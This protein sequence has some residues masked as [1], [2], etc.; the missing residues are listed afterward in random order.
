MFPNILQ[1]LRSSEGRSL[2]L[3]QVGS[4]AASQALK[5]APLQH[6]QVQELAGVA[7]EKSINSVVIHASH[8]SPESL[9]AISPFLAECKEIANF[10]IYSGSQK[11]SPNLQED[12]PRR[13]ASIEAVQDLVLDKSGIV[14][15]GVST[16]SRNPKLNQALIDMV[17]AKV[18][19][20][21]RQLKTLAIEGC[22]SCADV[23]FSGLAQQIEASKTI[24]HL[25]L[26]T[27]TEKEMS[28]L[29]L[30]IKGSSSVVDLAI[31]S[32]LIGA[33]N[34][35]ELIMAN[36]S[37]KYLNLENRFIPSSIG[38]LSPHSFID[39]NQLLQVCQAIGA[40]K[41]LSEVAIN[42]HLVARSPQRE[43]LQEN[44]SHLQ[45]VY[46]WQSEQAKKMALQ[47]MA[48]AI[49]DNKSLTILDLPQFSCDEKDLSQR[50]GE[51][52]VLLT[53]VSQSEQ[54]EK[55]LRRNLQI[56]DMIDDFAAVM[57]VPRILICMVEQGID[58][59]TIMSEEGLILQSAK[60]AARDIF[61]QNF[62]NEQIQEMSK[63]W[64]RPFAQD[65]VQSRLGA[66]SWPSL[67]AKEKI[68]IPPE[69]VAAEGYSLVVRTD[70]NA[71]KE[72]GRALRHCVGSYSNLCF[73]GS[74]HIISVVNE[75]GESLSTI[76][77]EVDYLDETIKL[78]QH[79]GYKNEPPSEQCQAAQKWFMEQ[80]LSGEIKINHDSLFEAKNHRVER[81]K[82]QSFSQWVVEIAGF[83]I[84]DDKEFANI[85]SQ[86]RR[87]VVPQHK[88]LVTKLLED[89]IEVTPQ[90]EIDTK[91][92]AIKIKRSEITPTS[93]ESLAR[94]QQNQGLK[95]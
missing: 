68:A 32:A 72:E 43:V 83:D 84:F 16:N 47:E 33:Q 28:L 89:P 55:L 12:L 79:H 93:A 26:S 78:S 74:S 90:L 17:A 31:D 75:K 9:R 37:I 21:D 20:K 57:I 73:S 34:L 29:A 13:L 59:K 65:Y 22:F 64:H 23:D 81:K 15:L 85:V 52:N 67:F 38:T 19:K 45:A 35:A 25:F 82:N 49:G 30:A 51:K 63:S 80:I 53:S 58:K 77:L 27:L 10:R 18:A 66:L 92:L 46:S 71:L 11:K 24:S 94:N 6:L 36:Q 54:F 60:R 88:D 91:L 2:Q 95:V 76:E 14:S 50:V 62:D 1:L 48:K 5:A 56:K 8:A 87:K 41:T 70:S 39:Y 44:L 86:Y 7:K 42:Y 4:Q 40:N 69:I 3:F 61:C